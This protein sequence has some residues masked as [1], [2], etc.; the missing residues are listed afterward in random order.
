MA[1]AR[2]LITG[3]ADDDERIAIIPRRRPVGF[4]LAWTMFLTLL[5]MAAIQIISACLGWET[6]RARNIAPPA[7]PC[8][9]AW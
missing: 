8:C 4:A 6:R 5:V 1:R 7:F 9:T 2:W 3:A